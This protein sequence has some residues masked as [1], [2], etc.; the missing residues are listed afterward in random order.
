MTSIKKTD[1]VDDKGEVKYSYYELPD[2]SS[3]SNYLNYAKHL[4][5]EVQKIFGD[6][7]KQAE[8]SYMKQEEKD[9]NYH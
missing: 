5:E 3:F 1:K 8:D 7:K 9:R 2:T 6:L 4:L